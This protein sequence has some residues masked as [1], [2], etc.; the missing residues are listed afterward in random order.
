MNDMYTKELQQAAKRL[1]DNSD[2][3]AIFETR[4]EELQQDVLHSV[5]DADIIASHAEHN[6]LVQFIQW[7]R[8]VASE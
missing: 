6:H 7:I 5:K 8:H 2:L 4:R 1:L 3:A